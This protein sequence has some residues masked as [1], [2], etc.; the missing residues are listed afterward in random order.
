MQ[1]KIQHLL[2]GE[3]FGVRQTSMKL[4]LVSPTADLTESLVMY[5]HYVSVLYIN[6]STLPKV[7]SEAYGYVISNNE[8]KCLD[9]SF[10]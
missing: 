10:R 3:V 7:S 4:P 5:Q 6:K 9:R 1:K 8:R 2:D